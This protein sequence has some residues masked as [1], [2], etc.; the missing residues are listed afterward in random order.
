MSRGMK[1]ETELFSSRTTNYHANLRT[2]LE[3]FMQEFVYLLLH[4]VTF[5][6]FL[7]Q[8][9]DIA[10][11]T[12]ENI[13]FTL[14]NGRHRFFVEIREHSDLWD[15]VEGRSESGELMHVV[16]HRNSIRRR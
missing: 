15:L 11:P 3:Y 1:E 6:W 13:F 7:H 16:A 14:S 12:P 4:N 5:S 8:A 9:T 2:A 10:G